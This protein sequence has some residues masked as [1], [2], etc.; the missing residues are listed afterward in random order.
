MKTKVFIFRDYIG[1]ESSP[2]CEGIMAHPAAGSLGVVCYANS[3]EFSP[4]AVE[5]LKTIKK[6]DDDLGDV[7]I[8]QTLDN[9][10]IFSWMGGYK[11]LVDPSNSQFSRSCD[12]SLLVPTEGVEPSDGFKKVV[13]DYLDSDD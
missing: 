8:F 11:R 12:T 5:L 3:V 10:I 6:S 9:T 4:E 7:N 2:E 13:G 1:I